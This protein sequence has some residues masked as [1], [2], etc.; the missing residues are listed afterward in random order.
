MEHAPQV[1]VVGGSIGGL[2]AACVLR[3]AGCDVD[4][5]ER[6]GSALTARGAGIAALEQTLRYPV[7]RAGVPIEQFCS[8]T[9]WIRFLRADGSVAHEQEHPYVFSSWNAVYGTL[10]AAFPAQRYHLG[11]EMVGFEDDGERVR[12][13]FA[14]GQVRTADL[15]VCADGISSAS[16]RRLLPRAAPRYAGYVAWRGVLPEADLD[17]AT[18]DRLHDALTYQQVP[19]GHILVYPIPATDGSVGV[20]RRLMNMVWYRNVPED[21]LADVLTDRNGERRPVSLPPGLVRD[22][23]VDEMRE[24]AHELLA[25]AVAR[26]VTAVREP[27][28]QAVF[29]LDVPRMAF[30]RV[31]LLG[32]AAF[33]A[34]PHAAAGTAKAAEDGWVLAE[35][36]VAHDGDV[37]AALGSWEQRQLRLGSDLLARTRAIGDTSQFGGGLTPG[38]PGLIF[39]LYEPGR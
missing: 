33:A 20:G 19:G 36:L 22:E 7:G 25:P 17:A 23:P 8:T 35:E 1:V 37:P 11:H 10:L 31:C 28:I 18:F 16:R 14:D 5:Y 34:R 12:V 3:D 13:T 30:G 15:L 26:F 24:Q 27:F 39:G 6:S 21:R 2:T 38:D 29:D 9:G 4:V 32:D